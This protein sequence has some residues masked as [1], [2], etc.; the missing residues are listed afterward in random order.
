MVGSPTQ[1]FKKCRQF[2]KYLLLLFCI[3]A[4]KGHGQALKEKLDLAIKQM[5][6]DVQLQH[7]IIGL[8]II[9]SKTGKPVYEH[10]AQVGLAAASTQKLFTSAAAFELLG[11]DYRYNSSIGYQGQIADDSLI[12]FLYV[13]GSGD[14]SFG[15][16]RYFAAKPENILN[17][18]VDGLRKAGIKKLSN[19]FYTDTIHFEDAPI[20][21]AWVWEDIGNYYGAGSWA[22]NWKENQ[23]NLILQSGSKTGE[24]VSILDG[25]ANAIGGKGYI[26]TAVSAAAGTGDNAYVYLPLDDNSLRLKGSIPINEQRFSISGAASNGPEY[27]I[28]DLRSKLMAVGLLQAEK[29][30]YHAVSRPVTA[31]HLVYNYRSPALDSIVYWFLKKSINLYGEALIKTIAYQK[32]GYG[33][34]DKGVELVKDFWSQQGIEKSAMNIVDGSGLSPQNRVT[35]DA[36]VK[37]LQYA[38]TRLWFPEFYEALPQ[39]NG[40]KMKSG[41][42]NAVRAYAGYHKAA[43]GKAYSFAIIVNNFN[44]SASA[45]IAKMF[46]VLDYLK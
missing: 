12:G 27:F 42:I 6:Q 44:G 37:V 17:G 1:Q 41:S 10:N 16:E 30:F 3:T 45:V 22:L 36:L 25:S 8:S 19:N 21:D 39:Y 33:A 15:S 38:K 24:P 2:K 13:K 26:N 34:T 14:P 11:K 18:I 35:P 31:G 7:G 28:N 23:Y 4:I 9:D 40:M 5:E 29:G 32:A 20:P 43:N 46:S